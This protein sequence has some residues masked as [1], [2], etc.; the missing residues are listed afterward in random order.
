MP[1]T[2]GLELQVRLHDTNTRRDHFHYGDDDEKLRMGIHNGPVYRVA[3]VNANISVAGAGIDMAERVMDCGDAGHILLSKTMADVL[4]QLSQWAPYLTD[5]GE[6][7]VKHGFKV[8]LYNL[9]IAELGNRERPKKLAPLAAPKGKSKSLVAGVAGWRWPPSPVAPGGSGEGEGVPR[10]PG[11]N[12]RFAR[13]QRPK[14]QSR[15]SPQRYD[16]ISVA[17]CRATMVALIERRGSAETPPIYIAARDSQ[18]LS[19]IK[20]LRASRV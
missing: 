6:L 1:G 19:R 11:I 13:M 10:P 5:L 18:S 15:L 9:A 7:T 3:D 20:E 2:G 17:L 16:P 12:R 4:L 14:P 8:H